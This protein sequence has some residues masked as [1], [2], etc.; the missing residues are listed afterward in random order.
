MTTAGVIILGNSGAGK[1]FLANVILGQEA[2]AHKVRSS[3]VTTETEYKTCQI[4]GKSYAIYNIPGLV[5]NKQE[6]IDLNKR[7]IDRAFIG[8]SYGVVLFVFG[9]GNGGRIRDEDVVAFDAI[10]NAYPLSDK[11][12]IIVLNNIPNDMSEDEK[13]EYESETTSE[14][15][16]LLKTGFEHTCFVY[17]INKSSTN[18]KQTVQTKLLDKIKIALPKIHKKEKEISLQA[19]ELSQLKKDMADL[20]KQ[21]E[22][23]RKRSREWEQAVS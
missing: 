12:S 10:N 16:G 8:H 19:G 2:F 6:R 14:L 13:S 11:S 17:Q 15:K 23:E 1:S 20:R 21:L 3:A 7:E 4:N 22:E 18:E 5:E 9:C